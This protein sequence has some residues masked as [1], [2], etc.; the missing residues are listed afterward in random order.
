ML[1]AAGLHARS[2]HVQRTIE[3]RQRSSLEDES[4]SRRARHLEPV[5]EEPEP[6]HVGRSV[7]PVAHEDLGRGAVEG[8]HPVDGGREVGIAR[9]TGAPAADQESGPQPLGQ[10][11]D[12]AWS[13]A[14]ST[15]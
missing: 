4:R 11:Q 9:P 7:D 15:S 10:D 2:R 13:R 12:I 8:A 1:R 6:G 14:A 3:R 5:A